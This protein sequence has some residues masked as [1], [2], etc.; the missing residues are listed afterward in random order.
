MFMKRTRLWLLSALVSLGASAIEPVDGVYHITSTTGL[1]EFAALVNNGSAASSNAVLDADI[2]YGGTTIGSSKTYAGTFDGQEHT[3][4]IDIDSSAE[5]AALFGKV[6]GTVKNLAVAGSLKSSNSLAA[7]IVSDLYAGTLSHCVC[8]VDIVLT[9]SGDATSGGL[10]ARNSA[11]NHCTIEYCTFAGTMSSTTAT[12]CAGIVAWPTG[13][14]DGKNDI[15]GCLMAGTMDF[16]NASTVF[17]I[18]R[19]G[20]DARWQATDCYVTDEKYK[21][22]TGVAGV[23]TDAQLQ[24][25]EACYLLNGSQSLA[26][27][28]HQTLPSDLIPTPF[29][30]HGIVYANGGLNCDGTPKGGIVYSN[31]NEEMRDE[32]AD[33]GNGYCLN[34]SLLLEDHITL[35]DGAY[36]LASTSD[37]AWF[38]AMVNSGKAI[39]ANAKLAA[40]ISYSGAP[41]GTANN[42]YAGTFDGQEHTITIDIDSS[43]EGAALFGTVSGTIKNLAVA[44]SLKSSNSLAAGIVSTLY[45]GTLSHCVCTVDIVL[46]K[47]G[48]ATCGGLVARNNAGNHCTIEYCTFAGTMS[49][50][51][52]TNCA[53]IIAWPTGYSNGKNDIHGCLMAGTMD[54]TNASTVFPIVRSGIDARWQA[55]DCYVTDEKYKANTGVA[56]VLTDEQLQ[57]GEAC[58]LLN[59]SQSLAAG[60]RQTLPSDLTPTP[61]LSHGTVSK[62]SD[63][64]YSTLYNGETAGTFSDNIEV[65]TGAVNGSYLTLT[66][67]GNTIPA[68]TAVVLKGA[69]G[70]YSFTP[71]AEAPAITGTN[72]LKGSD[73][74]VT[75]DANSIYVLAKQKGVT[76]FY[77]VADGLAIPEGK[78]YLEVAAAGIKAYI[79]N[80]GGENATGIDSITHNQQPTT[81]NQAYN[82]AGQRMQKAQNQRSTLVKG[83]YIING[84]KV[85]Y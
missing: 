6:S 54:F 63:A 76:G 18:V 82:L 62:M 13:W 61:F 40:D 4:T 57:S 71:A 44:G 66:K 26:S 16:T 46:T 43:A 39:T 49:S 23:L 55:T 34:C 8:T 12:N 7:G 79:F 68:A 21:T 31:I 74:T 67:Q 38:A 5:G 33:D 56:G 42:I 36:T 65:Y 77:L 20:I 51:T 27:G 3:I 53:G 41:I 25:G 2:N 47:S 80:F 17:P 37:L 69:E 30:S 72:E 35:V 10:V 1:E 24:S 58:Y 50:T 84:K 15:R 83:I 11:G 14:S 48:D 73:G 78:A 22:N 28:M 64:G 19:S 32:H 59:G 9:K 60:M 81:D 85:L 52:A 29:L 75:G 45:A 70:Y